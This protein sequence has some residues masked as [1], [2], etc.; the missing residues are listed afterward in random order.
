MADERLIFPVGFD[1]DSGVKDAS[2]EW[3][4]I[5][6]EMQAAIDSRP[7]N[8]KI[9]T[10]G[11]EKFQ[12]FIDRVYA[13]IE[14]LQEM[15]PEVFKESKDGEN[16]TKQ[17]QAM[18]TSINAVNAEM[19][20]LEKVWNN[21]SMEE[22]FDDKGQLTERA[23]ELKR[24]YVELYQ[25]QRTQGQTLQEITKEAIRLADQEIAKAEQKK[26][27]EAEYL[28]LLNLEENTL[29]NIRAKQGALMTKLNATEIGTNEWKETIAEVKRLDAKMK[30]LQI[31]IKGV[32]GKVKEA[33]NEKMDIDTSSFTAKLRDLEKRWKSLTAAQRKGSE[34]EALRKE[35]RELSA[36]AGNYASTL[37]SAVSAQDRLAKSQEKSVGAINA[38]NVEYQKQSS[39][40]SRLIQRLGIYTSIY[41]A[42]GMLR[43]IRETTAEFEL[44]EVALGAIIQDA[45]QAQVLFSQIKAAAV[46]SPYQIKELVDYTKQ[47]AAYGFEQNELFDTT[48]KLAD[49]SAGLGAD[50]SRIIL[51]VGQVSAATVLK[52]TELRQFTELG[53]PMVELLAEK[54]TQLR[55]E[56]VSTGEVFEMIS[57]KAVSFKMVEEILNDLTSAGGMFY[58]MQRKQAE[59]LAGQWSNLKDSIAIAYD[60]IGNTGTVRGAMEGVISLL[61]SMVDNWERTA[62]VLS[63]LV[64]GI[65]TYVAAVK[66]AALVEALRNRTLADNIKLVR[67]SVTVQPKW[68]AAIIGETRAKTLN[69]AM[70]KALRIA[71]LK[72][73]AATNVASKAFWRLTAA[74]MSNPY[75]IVIAAIAALGFTIFNMAK[76]TR[77]AEETVDDLN[78]SVAS[79][80][81]LNTS[82]KPLVDELDALSSKAEKTADEQKRLNQVTQELA[83]RYPAAISAVKEYGKE[84]DITAGKVRSLYEAEKEAARKGTEALLAENEAVLVRQKA[85]YDSYVKEITKGT[86]KVV[87]GYGPGGK[88]QFADVEMGTDELSE[89][90][91]KMDEL[92]LAIQN[93]ESAIKSAKIELGLLPSEAQQNI[94]AF[95]A[96]RKELEGFILSYKTADGQ[97]IQFFDDEQI[98]RFNNLN[99]A[100]A[101]TVKIRKENTDAVAK[102]NE[103]L[104]STAISDDTRARIM[105]ERNNAQ[106]HIDTADAIIKHFNAYSLLQEAK[107]KE[108]RTPLQLLNEE[109]SLLEKV[110][111][112]YKEFVKYMSSDD[113]KAKTEEY[114]ADTIGSLRFGAAFDT[115]KLKE[116]LTKYQDAARSLPES[117]KTVL[118]L[119]FKVDDV[120]WQDTLDDIKER[121]AE[122]AEA[123]S[124]SKEAKDFYDKMLG[125][126]GDRQLSADLTMNVY[127]GVGDDLKENIKN[128]LVQAFEGVDIAKYISGKNIDYKSLEKLIGTLPED[129]QANAR[130]IV[131]E[132][133]KSNAQ[134]IQDLYKTLIKF[135]DYESKRVTILRNGIEERRRIEQADLAQ[136]EKDRLKAA[137]QAAESKALA[138]LEYED[139]KSSDMYITMF[140]N[141]DYVSSDTLRRMRE[142]LLELKTTMGESLDPTQIKE[143]VTKMEDI[144][145]ELSR[146]NPFKTLAESIRTYKDEYG[147]ISRKELEGQLTTAQDEVD[148]QKENVRNSQKALLNAEK[149]VEVA[150]EKYGVDSQEARLARIALMN[151][152]QALDVEKQNLSKKEAVLDNLNDQA[153]AWR[154]IKKAIKEAIEG[155][156]G[157]VD[158]LNSTQSMLDSIKSLG[159]GMGAGEQFSGWM[160]ALSGI[161]GGAGST[162]TGI[163]QILSGQ[164]AQ[165]LANVVKGLSEVT[166]GIFDAS[167]VNRVAAANEEIA[168]QAQ[169]LEDLDRS[170]QALEKSAEE[171]FGTEYLDNYSDRLAKLY[172]MQAAY[173]AQADAERDKGKKEDAEATKDY[174]K[175]AQEV[176]DQIA[177]MYGE[178]SERF[179]GT[180]LGS[181][182]RDFANAWLEAYKT[183]GNTADAIGTKFREMID[184][185]VA[186]SVIAGVMKTA[187]DPV[188]TML[189]NMTA[190]DLYDPK[191]WQK[192]GTAVETATEDADVGA[193]NAMRMLEAMG[194]NIREMGQGLAGISKDIATTSEESILGL[195]AG[196][197]TQNFYISQ[198][199]AA[200]LRMEMLMQNGAGGGVNIQDLVTIQNQHLAHLPNIAAN[201]A[202]T[203]QRCEEIL[204]QVTDIA[205]NLGRVISPVG[206]SSTHQVHTTLS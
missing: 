72:E 107:G 186:E 181:A 182:A 54:F 197:N 180:D 134:I 150:E 46:E 97:D 59:T 58:D 130:K 1:L 31:S 191:F 164:W 79:L 163:G 56:V 7:M 9:D 205:M 69:L 18:E 142:K 82:V 11:I 75:A 94:D 70:T 74:M 63:G 43:D 117:D 154:N 146:K 48:M 76:N 140:E 161:V 141:L 35:W 50:M 2:K 202:G 109:V 166:L 10:H 38:Q 55:G 158:W 165:G 124:R 62:A 16:I 91:R 19:R 32:S 105:Q 66:S 85:L 171:A 96:W 6:K 5:S 51:A 44:Q 204:A 206:I 22:K 92:S 41:A 114:F 64:T 168:R 116:I 152:R 145:A 162:A 173:Q 15:F 121:V 198:I 127:G 151:A 78:K 99:D 52:G 169:I 71:R 21:L 103:T 153:R 61:K 183:F 160:E 177:E 27:K 68:V 120:S 189:D 29:D 102:Y 77:T 39:Y 157:I 149:E 24:A 20:N 8:I 84:V 33:K 128:Q 47:L 36:Q 147:K 137:S 170:Y 57:D 179:A 174:E 148:V 119:G 3:Q 93:T 194:I 190:D 193:T 98:G 23:Q 156:D 185:M 83:N 26:A 172:A 12:T 106:A 67:T 110:Y 133:I 196:I 45:H 111:A 155:E 113:A 81:K 65:A 13:S 40:I 143:I 131:E 199:H 80:A 132:G 188:F 42:A 88:A 95:G 112:K 175:Q 4:R 53:I 104:K 73:V 178:I 90:K 30:E 122:L 87:V 144:D 123:V 187:L 86:K 139:F 60:E 136:S 89:L 49:I 108:D 129:M 17:F 176:A 203:L 14:D 115:A 138:K 37:R 34:G 200:V 184:N 28:R 125:M 135:E 25:S 192:L 100:L 101:E 167:Y 126:T 201:T 118:E 159:E 195:A